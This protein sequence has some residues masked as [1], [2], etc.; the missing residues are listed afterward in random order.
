MLNFCYVAF[1]VLKNAYL[2]QICVKVELQS[3]SRVLWLFFIIF[4]RAKSHDRNVHKPEC[5]IVHTP[6]I[7]GGHVWF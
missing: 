7:C 3:V 1:C 4:V 6:I 2:T 5:P